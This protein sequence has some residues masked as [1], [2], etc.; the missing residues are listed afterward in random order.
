MKKTFL[1]MSLSVLGIIN[2]HAQNVFPSTGA[3][4]IG[5]LTPNAS[6]LLEINST[7]KGLL[8]SR[9]TKT[10][11]APFHSLAQ[12]FFIYQTTGPP[13]SYFLMATHGLPF[14]PKARILL[15]L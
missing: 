5:T 9:M 11:P 15:Y 2:A 14:R 6:S 3:A 10:Q 4:G 1:L 12:G 13:G 7:S 8:I